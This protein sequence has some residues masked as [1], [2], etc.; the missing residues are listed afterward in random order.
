MKGYPIS[1]SCNVTGFKG[2]AKQDF[3]FIVKKPN[4]DLN[5]ISTIDPNFPYRVFS[6]RVRIKDIEIQM[7]SGSSV[8][9]RI[10]NLLEEDAGDLV[11]ETPNTDGEYFGN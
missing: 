2:P 5:M 7:L 10:K 9:L 3:Q 4:M 6:D 8:L 1:I 11:C